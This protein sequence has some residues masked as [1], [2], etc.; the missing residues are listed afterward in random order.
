MPRR[1]A[2]L[3]T[4]ELE[5]KKSSSEDADGSTPLK[6]GFDRRKTFF[7]HKRF[8]AKAHAGEA[9]IEMI[10]PLCKQSGL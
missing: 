6:H 1:F 10:A 8:C 2:V 9:F 5:I 3:L 7:L 4:C